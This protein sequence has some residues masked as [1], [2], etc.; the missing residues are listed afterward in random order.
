MQLTKVDENFYKKINTLTWK[1][2]SEMGAGMYID[3]IEL[4]AL[5]ALDHMSQFQQP[6]EFGDCSG[7]LSM[8]FYWDISNDPTIPYIV[9]EN[10]ET[11]RKE[12]IKQGRQYF[13][14]SLDN[15]ADNE[16]YWT[17]RFFTID[18][19]VSNGILGHPLITK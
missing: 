3:S 5:Y 12:I 6:K 17:L 7:D 4:I 14:L 15:I 11:F 13:S 10:P 2:I 19:F 9:G 16:Y 18:P 1:D 8:I